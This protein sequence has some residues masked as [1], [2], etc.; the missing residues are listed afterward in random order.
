MPSATSPPV[1][2]GVT[3][4]V[5]LNSRGIVLRDVYDLRV[6]GFDIDDLRHLLRNHDLRTGL[7]V[8]CSFGR[9][10]ETLYGCHEFATLIVMGLAER[11]DPVQI[12]GDVA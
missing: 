12:I 9:R 1:C 11:G 6:G 8:A 7:R 2:P 5:P 4:G 3:Y 10:A